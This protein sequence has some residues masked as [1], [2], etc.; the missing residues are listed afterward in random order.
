VGEAPD[1]P[2]WRLVEV[3]PREKHPL[4]APGDFYVGH[5]ECMTCGYPHALAPDLM[6]WETD[7]DGSVRHC[8]FR[9]QPESAEELRQAVAACVGSCCGALRYKGTDEKIKA[10]LREAGAEQALD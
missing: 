2:L 6:A 4:D 8:Y 7:P 10:A 9:K 5:G 1:A 3:S